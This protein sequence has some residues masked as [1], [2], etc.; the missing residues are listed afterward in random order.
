M[1]AGEFLNYYTNCLTKFPDKHVK[2][3]RNKKSIYTTIYTFLNCYSNY[4]YLYYGEVDNWQD[5]NNLL[6]LTLIK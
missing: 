5:N 4:D 1:T 3:K 6:T 2:I